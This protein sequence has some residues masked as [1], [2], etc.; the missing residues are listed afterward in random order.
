MKEQISALMD[1]E[2]D[3]PEAEGCL[4]RLRDDPEMH[5]TWDVYHL[6]GDALRGHTAGSLPASFRERLA[7]EPVV[8]APRSRTHKHRPA[9][10]ALSAAASVAAVAYVGWMAVPFLAPQP[11]QVA[12]SGP[13]PAVSIQP[14]PLLTVVPA[15]TQPNNIVPITSGMSDYL[16]A[17]Q[18]FSSS[19]AMVGV[20][21]YARAVS[22]DFEKR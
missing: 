15:P 22:Q 1:S 5:D 18:R 13:A 3:D 12:A 2:L 10:V 8:L 7:R 6:I 14:T 19:S 9:W 21:P 20:A 17:H 16:M 11:Q 4:R